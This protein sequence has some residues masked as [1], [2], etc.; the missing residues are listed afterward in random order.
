M[1]S[2]VFTVS[3]AAVGGALEVRVIEWQPGS[4]YPDTVEL[5]LFECSDATTVA[6]LRLQALAAMHRAIGRRLK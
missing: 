1:S 2:M 4:V 3:A 5:V 6:E